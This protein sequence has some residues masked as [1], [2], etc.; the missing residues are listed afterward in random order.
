MSI[1]QLPTVVRNAEDHGQGAEAGLSWLEG[2]PSL[3]SLEE[4]SQREW[5]I[6]QQL[7][8][9]KGAA[10]MSYMGI[11]LQKEKM[12]YAKTPGWGT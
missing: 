11:I 1:K 8:A 3:L 9:E 12:A 10:S 4:S 2:E 7:K 5:F 6:G